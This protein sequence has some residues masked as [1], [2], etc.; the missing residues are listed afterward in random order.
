MIEA[1]TEEEAIATVREALVMCGSFGEYDAAS[2]RDARG[3]VW[4]GPFCR[5]WD[6]ID[7]QAVPRRED[8]LCT[9]MVSA[10][11]RSRYCGS[12]LPA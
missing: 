5:S 7:W 1:S 2:V 8:G 10:R 3:E 6:E 12:S 11:A 4:Q 9:P